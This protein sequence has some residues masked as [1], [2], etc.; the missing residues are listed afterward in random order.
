MKPVP[1]LARPDVRLFLVSFTLLFT[2][3]LLIRWIPANVIYVGSVDD[4]AD[5]HRV[6]PAC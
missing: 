4:D 5:M 6:H 3:L 2:E 1:L